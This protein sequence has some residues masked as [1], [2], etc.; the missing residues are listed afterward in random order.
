[1]HRIVRKTKPCLDVLDKPHGQQLM[2]ACM[3]TTH[4][5]PRAP[6][7]LPQCEIVTASE[8]TGLT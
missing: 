2:L 7:D 5:T 3:H 1:M 8:M 6:R 4:I